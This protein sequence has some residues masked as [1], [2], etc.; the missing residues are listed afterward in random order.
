MTIDIALDHLDALPF[1]S[2]TPL[3]KLATYANVRSALKDYSQIGIL[4][5]GVLLK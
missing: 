1:M 2:F 3:T 4:D 5:K